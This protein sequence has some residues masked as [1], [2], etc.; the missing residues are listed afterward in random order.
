MFGLIAAGQLVQAQATQVDETHFVFQLLDVEHTNH[1]VVF[2]TG[3][4][5]FPAGFGGAVHF[6][7]PGD[8]GW[9][10]LGHLTNEKPSAIFK[11]ARRKS[12]ADANGPAGA[13]AHSWGGVATAMGGPCAQVG[14][15]PS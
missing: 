5:P 11:L 14:R 9:L 3:A 8:E 2:L 13:A 6:R 10:L 15:A 12:D 1:V 4:V 7:W